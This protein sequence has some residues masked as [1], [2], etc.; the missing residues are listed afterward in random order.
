MEMAFAKKGKIA[1]AVKMIVARL[2]KI[3]PVAVEDRKAPAEMLDAKAKTKRMWRLH[4]PPRRNSK[5]SVSMKD[6]FNGVPP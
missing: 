5:K 2:K 1:R 4:V 3:K 6:S